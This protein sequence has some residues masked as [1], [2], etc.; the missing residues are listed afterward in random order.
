M[1]SQFDVET[2]EPRTTDRW[3]VFA[4]LR[5]REYRLLIAAVSLS[6]FAEG[7]WTVVAALQVIAL[8][9][10]PAALSLVA[11]CAGVGLVAFVLVGGIAADRLNR[12]N[13]IITVEVIN[14]VAV[15]TI[16]ALSSTGTLRLWHMAVAATCLGIAVAFFFPAYSALLPRILPAE[17]LLAA[18]GIEGVV[19][20]VLQQAI[21]PAA[22]GVLVGLTF[23]SVGATTVAVLF[24]V[25]LVLLVATRP[26]AVPADEKP[27]EHKHVLHDLRE[28]FTFMTRTPWLLWTLLVA[29]VY[30]LV[31]LGP[32]EVLMPFIAQQRFE[33]GPRAYGFII[34]GF[35]IGSAVGAL[36]VSS[37]RMPRRYLTAMMAI[38]GLGALPL[39]VVG[40][41]WSFPVMLAATILVGIGEGASMVIWGTLLQLR[42]PTEMLGR[43]SSLDFFVSL[44]F[45]P[46]S[47]AIAGPLSKIVPM[48][49][50]FVV[51]GVLPAILTAIAWAVARMR[52]DEL[53]HPL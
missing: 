21:G 26:T 1:S 8:D 12:R 27:A 16:A 37:A 39:V 45:M 22:A 10:D 42:V 19:R 24:G 44:V 23:P 41:T 34:A 35:G 38:W 52:A 9:N 2:P 49:W 28:G 50:I 6:I 32:I 46:V 33:D 17:Q 13:I 47:F 31:V 53:A 14:L 5:F 3:R 20:P 7:M 18:N 43:V 11:T 40:S 36:A 29:S 51:S 48:Q 25:G 4:P 30:V 15:S